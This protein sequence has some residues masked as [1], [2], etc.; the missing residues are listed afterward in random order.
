MEKYI[1]FSP[2]VSALHSPEL[3]CA[4]FDPGLG[5]DWLVVQIAARE[6]GRLAAT[7]AAEVVAAGPLVVAL[8][9][10]MLAAAVVGFAAAAVVAAR[11]LMLGYSYRTE[12]APLALLV[13]SELP[14]PWLRDG[15]EEQG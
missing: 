2:S 4:E 11:E 1:P 8:V 3:V 13:S 6:L 15:N 9:A 10:A 14:D 12:E 5:R 7:A